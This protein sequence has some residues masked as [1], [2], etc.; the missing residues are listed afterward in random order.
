MGEIKK[1]Q[2]D[3]KCK[4]RFDWLLKSCVEEILQKAIEEDWKYGEFRNH[5]LFKIAQSLEIIAEHFKE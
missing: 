5:I 1:E 3:E 4:Q 2:W